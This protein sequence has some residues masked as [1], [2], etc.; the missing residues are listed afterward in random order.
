MGQQF[1]PMCHDCA[2]AADLDYM[3]LSMRWMTEECDFCGKRKPCV[4]LEF[5]LK[6]RVQ[7]ALDQ[8]ESAVDEKEKDL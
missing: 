7:K 8:Q 4:Q 2:S 6:E 5:A 1:I 3:F